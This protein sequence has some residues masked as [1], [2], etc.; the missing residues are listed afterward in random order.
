MVNIALSVIKFFQFAILCYPA[1]TGN[2]IVAVLINAPAKIRKGSKGYF[3]IMG[4]EPLCLIG[5]YTILGIST[6]S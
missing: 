3:S 5:N 2:P 1:N 4:V 6:P